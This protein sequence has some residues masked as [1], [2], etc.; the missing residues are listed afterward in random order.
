MNFNE[1][2]VLNGVPKKVTDEQRAVI[3]KKFSKYTQQ[4]KDI[5]L[6]KSQIEAVGMLYEVAYAQGVQ[7]GIDIGAKTIAE[8]YK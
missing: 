8:V 3:H 7:L 1:K 6:D 5:G 2:E 4:L